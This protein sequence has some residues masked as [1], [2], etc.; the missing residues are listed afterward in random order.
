MTPWWSSSRPDIDVSSAMRVGRTVVQHGEPAPPDQGLRRV[1]IL[2]TCAMV[3]MGFGA[4]GDLP[5]A[6]TSILIWVVRVAVWLLVVFEVQAIS[7]GRHLVLVTSGSGL[8]LAALWA[9]EVLPVGN[10][11]PVVQML[12]LV[13]WVLLIASWI[14]PRRAVRLLGGAVGPRASPADPEPERCRI[15]HADTSF[16]PAWSV[17]PGRD[18][19]P[20]VALGGVALL[21]VGT[22]VLK[23]PP[24]WYSAACELARVVVVATLGLAAGGRLR[25]WGVTASARAP[26]VL[27]VGA[28]VVVEVALLQAPDLA[29][30]LGLARVGVPL[31]LVAVIWWAPR[32][33]R[34]LP[35]RPEWEALHRVSAITALAKPLT[36]VEAV[37]RAPEF[38]DLLDQALAFRTAATSEYLES[39]AEAARWDLGAGPEPADRTALD[40]RWQELHAALEAQ[41][42]PGRTWR[43]PP[44]AGGG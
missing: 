29:A 40:G 7:P 25:V 3:V 38:L 8:T 22:G 37:T 31:M 23:P 6:V 27:A 43:V 14:W 1:V 4:P 36:Q 44:P 13:A 12:G 28:W 11:S 39:F 35:R 2:A 16:P 30:W 26:L 15:T 10:G 20:W 24:V 9:A 34:I 42:L 32:V 19:L 5:K 41:F 33:A 17:H 21:H 18:W